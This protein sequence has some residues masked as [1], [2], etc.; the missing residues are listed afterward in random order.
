MEC[1]GYHLYADD[2]Q[3]YHSSPAGDVARLSTELN[4]DL[5]SVV[6]WSRRNGLLLNVG[7]TQALFVSRPRSLDEPPALLL[8]GS[9][10]SFSSSL[11][12]LGFL[13][14]SRLSWD[15]FSELVCGRVSA[16]LRRLRVY[17]RLHVQTKVRLFKSLILPFFNL[18]APNYA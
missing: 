5:S 18:R 6:A 7:K 10:I 15:R 16:A 4:R 8:D 14:D 17:S 2:L 1:S 9:P 13:L 12:D 3:L 11:N